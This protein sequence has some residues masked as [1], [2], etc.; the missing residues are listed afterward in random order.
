MARSTRKLLTLK[1]VSSEH[2]INIIELIEDNINNVDLWVDYSSSNTL[3]IKVAGTRD[4]V[5]YALHDIR[6]YFSALKTSLLRDGHGLFLHDH[7]LLKL[8]SGLYLSED[9]INLTLKKE[10]NLV[11]I[12]LSSGTFKSDAPLA[13]VLS[14]ITLLASFQGKLP[15]FIRSKNLK[16]VMISIATQY[17]KNYEEIL[18]IA[19]DLDIIKRQDDTSEWILTCDKHNALDQIHTLLS[20]SITN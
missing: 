1:T 2:A 8:L 19:Q 11:E 12:N 15:K 5:Q 14:H 6:F 3:Q 10:F 9:L 20:P 13:D 16:F 7:K 18:R 17:D 4:N